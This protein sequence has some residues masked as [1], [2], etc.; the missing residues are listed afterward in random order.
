MFTCDCKDTT[1]FSNK[2]SKTEQKCIFQTK[3]VYFLIK[4]YGF[5]INS[6]R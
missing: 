4:Y 3:T 2:R 1:Y 5:L 6:Y